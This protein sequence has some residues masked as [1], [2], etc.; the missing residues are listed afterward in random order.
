MNEMPIPSKPGD[1][2]PI[3][4]RSVLICLTAGLILLSIILP[5]AAIPVPFGEP[6]YTA[7]ITGENELMPGNVTP[8][9]VMVRNSG[10]APEMIL[11][12]VDPV[13]SSPTIGYGAELTLLPGTAPVTIP[14]TPVTIPVLPPHTGFPVTFPVI[15]PMDAPAGSY[16]L[17]LQV[18]SQYA[19][20]VAMEG[21]SN[22]FTYQPSNVTLRI[23][24]TI[25]AVVRVRADDISSS[26]LSSAQ[27]GRITAAITNTGQFAGTRATAELRVPPN[28]LLTPYQGSYYLGTFA[29]GEQRTVEWRASVREGTDSTTAP[30]TL[31]ISY[32][33]ENGILTTSE[34]VVIGI[35][36]GSGPKFTLTYD[37]PEIMPGESVTVRVTYTNTGDAP[38]QNAAAT[39]VPIPP[40]SSPMA[41]VLLG[42]IPPGGKAVVDYDLALERTALVKPYGVL[43][44]IKYRGEDG[45]LA[46]SDP[47]HIELTTIPPGIVDQLL[48]PLSLVILLGLLLIAGYL[49]L[50]RKGRLV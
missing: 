35:P 40:V 20:A 2:D 22:I 17:D 32:L 36:V 29:P 9:T 48:S 46:I 24:V 18:N 47:M 6:L 38:A 19:Q 26:N 39:I 13:P 49:Y 42:T 11:D 37:P 45:L 3:R 10:L 15:V 16:L 12:P 4:Q 34:P 21:M 1:P 30:A 8:V 27:N 28:G 50:E 33:D 5:A 43:T 7:T 31:V 41:S 25:K 14:A 44:D 23:P